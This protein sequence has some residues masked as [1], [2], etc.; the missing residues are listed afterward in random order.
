MEASSTS[1]PSPGE[2][3]QSDTESRPPSTLHDVEAPSPKE[4]PDFVDWDGPDDPK[5]PRNWTFRHRWA[6]TAVVSLFTF[7]SPLASS[8]VAP[9]LPQISRELNLE[10]GSVLESMT[11]SVFVLAYAVG[12]LIFGPLSETYG[13]RLILQGSNLFFLA[14]NIACSRAKTSSQLLAF[15]FLAG[16]GGSAPLAIGG[17]TIAD[18]WS[19]EERGMA[20]SLYS[21]APLTGPAIGPVAG[22]WIAERASWRWV[23]YSTSIADGVI[24]LVGLW[25]LTETYAPTI[26]A[27]K[28]RALRKS[29]GDETI[30]TAHEHKRKG[31]ST[32]KFIANAL[33]RSIKFLMFDPVMTI[34]AIYMAVMYGTMYLQL[35]TFASIWTERYGESVGIAGLNYLFMGAGFTLGAQLGARVLDRIYKHLKERNNGIPTPEMRLP[36]LAVGSFMLPA[37]LLL[38]GWTAEYRIFW[39]VPD[40]GVFIYCTGIIASFLCI[41]TYI[42]DTYGLHAASAVAAVSSFRSIAGFAFPLFST[43]MFTALGIGWGNSVLALIAL[44]IGCPSPF[45]FYKYGPQLRAMARSSRVPT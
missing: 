22:A 2:P 9:A 26:L 34:M 43:K 6:A 4:K 13:R 44:V 17:G 41:Q 5:N 14:F 28:A 37:G 32:W 15:R 1:K 12:P 16:L 19:P 20:M 29:T 45:L 7:M 10:Q 24:Q 39:L 3:T 33:L 30:C 21:L 25:Y 27:A 8:M 40:I 31:S 11:L 35:T 18:L 36:L 23:F 38:Y 42:V